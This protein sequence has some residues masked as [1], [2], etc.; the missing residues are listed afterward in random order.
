MTRNLAECC[1]SKEAEIFGRYGLSA[2]EGHLLLTVCEH[3]AIS[4]SAAAAGC[5]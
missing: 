1:V 3:K 2:A 4:P 5:S